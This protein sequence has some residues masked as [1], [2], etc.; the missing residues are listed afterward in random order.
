M[1]SRSLGVRAPSAMAIIAPFF[2]ATTKA[3]QVGEA[4]GS[5]DMLPP[6]LAR[7]EAAPVETGRAS[8]AA[9]ASVG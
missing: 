1:T 9:Y 3:F 2:A 7:A 6:R 8:L 4:G 5:R